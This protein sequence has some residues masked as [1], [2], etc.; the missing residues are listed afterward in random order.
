MRCGRV[1]RVK[2]ILL[3]M[4][5]GGLL[6]AAWF[7]WEPILAGWHHARAWKFIE[8]RHHPEAFR[9]AQRA[10]WIARDRPE[11]LFLLARTHRRLGNVACVPALLRRAAKLGGDQDRADR[12]MWLLLA[13][14]GRLREAEPHLADLLRDPR[15]DGPDICEAFVQGY[16]ANLRTTEAAR[17]LDVWQDASPLDPWPRF[18]RGYLMQGLGRRPEAIAAYR[19][20]LAV[21]P[22]ET[23][24]RRRLA[25]VLLEIRETAEAAELL[26]RCVD[27]DPENPAILTAWAECLFAQGEVD[28]AR[29]LLDR[30]LAGGANAFEARRLLGDIEIAQGRLK[31]ALPHLQAALV[32]R[33]YDTTTHNA[34]GKVLRALGRADEAKPHFDYV[35]EAEQSLNRMEKQLRLAV[36]RPGDAGLR[37]EIASTLLKYGSPDDGAKWLR[38]VLQLEPNHRGAHRALV[39]YYE[40]RGDWQS[41]QDHRQQ[42]SPK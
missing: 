14:V 2:R 39:A 10:L 30:L 25:E 36:E 8:A 24:M 5:A 6:V 26:R 31:E 17:L 32:Q 38:S 34:L 41:A 37:Y 12:E 21:A 15:D 9:E 22:D 3:G 29:E 19:E 27:E 4:A 42:T 16:F 33:P 13:Q 11:T 23:T 20:G 7:L 35:T 18:M 1:V 40:A 28:R